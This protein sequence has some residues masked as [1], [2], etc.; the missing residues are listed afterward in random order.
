MCALT[1]A[2]INNNCDGWY[3]LM[4]CIILEGFQKWYE[5]H[6]V[7]YIEFIGDGQFSISYTHFQSTLGL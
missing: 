3:S 7:R 1:L 2:I 4:I 6:G 5:Q